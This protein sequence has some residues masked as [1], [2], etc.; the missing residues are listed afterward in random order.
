MTTPDPRPVDEN[1]P[2]KPE[3]RGGDSPEDWIE[4]DE[5]CGYGCNCWGDDET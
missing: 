4:E 1:A 2:A 5:G 3:I